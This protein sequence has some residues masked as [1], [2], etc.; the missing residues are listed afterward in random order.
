M[1]GV[2]IRFL[3]ASSISCVEMT[4]EVYVC[5]DN[6]H[7]NRFSA[8]Y[9]IDLISSVTGQNLPAHIILS[10]G[11]TPTMMNSILIERESD[12]RPQFVTISHLDENIVP[13]D[14]EQ[15]RIQHPQCYSTEIKRNLIDKLSHPVRKHNYPR[16][17]NID[18][19]KLEQALVS[20]NGQ[21]NLDGMYS[22]RLVSIPYGITEGIIP[23]GITNE[24]LSKTVQVRNDYESEVRDSGR[25]L[26]A[27]L[28]IGRKGHIGFVES[29]TPA[30]SGVQIYRLSNETIDDAVADG[31]VSADM[32]AQYAISMSVEFIIEISKSIMVM[33]TG[34]R[35]AKP[36]YNTLVPVPSIDTPA[37]E[38]QAWAE[39]QN[40]RCLFIV[41]EAAARLILEPHARNI[42]REKNILV[43][44]I[45]NSAI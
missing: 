24:I 29:G 16:A 9:G 43:H 28:G 5:R 45:Q 6:V 20:C 42:L 1:G 10:T 23:Y 36:V 27:R 34:P 17:M 11:G 22:G 39:N 31:Y 37:S 38:L 18:G 25:V 15:D 19:R 35:K 44:E 2:L 8:N 3:N 33:A 14:T 13:G 12:W 30:T 41:D 40:R 32:A 26:L 21:I 4:L 7:V